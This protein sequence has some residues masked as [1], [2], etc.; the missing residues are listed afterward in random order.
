MTSIFPC[1]CDLVFFLLLTLCVLAFVFVSFEILMED[2]G[3]DN[4]EYL[5]PFDATW[6]HKPNDV[7]LLLR[8][9]VRSTL[10]NRISMLPDVKVTL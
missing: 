3:D 10:S 5:V 6:P 7:A 8:S 9:C 4:A 2:C 1:D